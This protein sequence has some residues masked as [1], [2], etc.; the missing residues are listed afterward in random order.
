MLWSLVESH[1]ERERERERKVWRS[2]K[3][4]FWNSQD[5]TFKKAHLWF[6]IDRKSVSIDWNRQKLTKNLKKNF[7]WSKNRL[8]QSKI[9]KNIIL[10]KIIWFL[11]TFL[12]ALN[13]RNK[14]HEYKMKCFSKT[15]VLNPVFPN[16]RLSN[17]L[18]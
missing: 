18:P 16:L 11:K 17:N 3:K 8:D 10:E 12:K 7:D 6:S 4:M 2:L 9:W 1:R 14:M 15:Q 5:L 13:I